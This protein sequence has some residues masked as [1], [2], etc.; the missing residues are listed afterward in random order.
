MAST[1]CGFQGEPGAYSEA[2]AHEIFSSAGRAVTCRG[3]ASFDDVFA[4]LAAGTT[5]YAAVPV[6]NTLGGSIHGNYDLLLRYHGKVHILGEHSFRVRHTLLALPG[7][8]KADVKKAMSHPQALAQTDTYLRA[9]GIEPVAAYDTA[10][11]AKLVREQNLRDTAAIASARAAE[12][13]GLEVLDFGIE[14]DSNNFTR[15][16]LL[17]RKRPHLPDAVDCKTAIVFVP[18]VNEAG[19]LF[20]VLSAFAVRELDLSKIESRPYRPGAFTAAVAAGAAAAAANGDPLPGGSPT[21]RRRTAAE[22]AAPPTP[23]GGGAHFQYAFYADVLASASDERVSNALRHLGELCASVLVLGCFPRDGIAF[24]AAEDANADEAPIFRPARSLPLRIAIVGFGTFGQF[25]ARQWLR[26]GHTV[27][28]QSR[29]DYSAEAAAMGASFCR[30]LDA[31]AAEACDVVVVATS[32]L[33]FETVLRSLPP[34]LVAGRLVVDMLSV[35]AHAKEAMLRLLPSDADVICMHPMFGPESGKHGWGGLPCVYE[36]VRVG[37]HHRAA[38]L[39]ALFEEEGCRMVRM[40][41]ERH[42]QLA[43]ASQFVTHLTGRLL[44]KLKLQP[45][46]I[47]TK[48]FTALLDLVS[49]TCKD[50]FDLFY[51][52]YSHNAA[53][54]EQLRQISAAFEEL[55]SDLLSYA[56]GGSGAPAS[57]G[58]GV[59]SSRV[60]GLAMSKTVQVTDLAAALRR[61]GKQVISLSVGEPDFVPAAPVMEAAHEALTQGLVK[62]TENAGSRALREAICLYLKTEKKIEYAPEQIVCSNGAKQS[63]LQ[64]MLSLCGP[65]DE[66]LIP[67]PHW[68]SYPQMALLCGATPVILPTA[69]A[70]GYCLQPDELEGA[71]TPATKVLILVNPSNPTGAVHPPELLEGL[72]AVLRKWPKV[73]VISDEIYE[74]I[75][76]DSSH[77]AFAAL[78]GMYERTVT[79]NGMSKGQAMTGFRLGYLAAS[80]Q[81]ATACAKVQSQNTSCPCSVSQHAGITALNGVPP[82]FRDDAVK[83]FRGK[84]DYVLGRL[85]AMAGVTCPTPEGAFYAFPDVSAFFGRAAPDGAV[86]ATAEAVCMYLLRDHQLALVPGEAFG[87]PN[88][89]RISYATDMGTLQDAMDRMERG[90][91][92][93]KP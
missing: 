25:V 53:S 39:L 42:D 60:R 22:E 15:F 2:A 11:S 66:V 57:A 36:Q 8:A 43:S 73:V 1:I 33:S 50:S 64:A 85:R 45:N 29:S 32:V 81:I 19:A 7:V 89:L 26:R 4:A 71:L 21:K 38:R 18:R 35:K 37:D 90:L 46:P 74:H 47:A 55:R 17:G 40:S 83:A 10:G 52:L 3:F 20:K 63:I 34:A 49:N 41:C 51:A 78:D 27:V 16:L 54:S 13:H 59:L 24:D 93:I 58:D 82:S 12:V 75:V 23:G 76:Y 56:P 88:C 80:R 5:E 87:D 77:V 44:A 61:E 68:V 69:A 65:G 31:L 48:G 9:A 79:V 62:Y 84:R 72:A 91:A 28:A 14:D 30:T 92:A 67:A 6:E 70:N 86:L